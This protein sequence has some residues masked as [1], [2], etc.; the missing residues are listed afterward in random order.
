MVIGCADSRVDPT[1][2]FSASPGELLVVRNV[3]ALVPPY[4]EHGTYHGTSAALEFAVC[5]LHVSNI[6]VLGHGMCGGIEAALAGAEHRPVGRFI[7]PWV[8]LLAEIRDEVLEQTGREGD[9][10]KALEQAAVRQSL[11]NMMSF[12]FI[13]E[14]V[15]DGQLKLDCAWFSIAE[16]ELLW[17]DRSS[18]KFEHVSE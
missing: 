3:A 9:P 6:V 2:I 1:T 8:G 14:A 16:G 12:S 18:S 11:K 17:L 5:R 10:Q 13:T 4:E 15:A 7:D